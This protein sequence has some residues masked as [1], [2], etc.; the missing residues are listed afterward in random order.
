MTRVAPSSNR[1]SVTHVKQ[2]PIN[3]IVTGRR[4]ALLVL[5]S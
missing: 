5:E 3:R 1:S 2:M 4:Q